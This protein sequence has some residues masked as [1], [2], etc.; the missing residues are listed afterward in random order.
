MILWM[1]ERHR[2]DRRRVFITGLSAGGAMTSIMLAL[3]PG[4]FAGG[5]II[6]GLPYGAA[7]NVVEA[8]NV[9][10]EGR[11]RAAAEWGELVRNAVDHQGPWP[12]VSV[13]HGSADGRVHPSNAE[14]ILKQWSDLHGLP[15]APVS[16]LVSGDGFRHRRWHNGSAPPVLESYTVFDLAHGTPI[17]SEKDGPYA[18]GEFLIDAGISSSQ[19]IAAFWGLIP[20]DAADAKAPPPPHRSLLTRVLHAL[21]LKGR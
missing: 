8:L 20:P 16:D 15:P 18:G 1:L 21:G 2:L 13:W 19:R 10:S 7:A 3:Y 9:M 14:E 11:V 12:R 17:S 6:A 4:L 5:A